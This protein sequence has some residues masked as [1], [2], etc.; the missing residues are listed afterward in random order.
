MAGAAVDGVGGCAVGAAYC[1]ASRN[2]VAGPRAA[3]SLLRGEARAEREGRGAG[4]RRVVQ[5]VACGSVPASLW[6]PAAPCP[7]HSPPSPHNRLPSVPPCSPG[8][9]PPSRHRPC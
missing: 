6:G 7:G 1:H 9:P 3:R 2:Q 4:P 5:D 8:T